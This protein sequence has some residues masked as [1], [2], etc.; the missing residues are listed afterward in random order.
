MRD[1]QDRAVEILQHIL[2]HLLARDIQM[3]CGLVQQEE[4]GLLQGQ[5]RQRQPAA[6]AAAQAADSFED[7]IFLKEK[8]AQIA[9]GFTHE[10]VVMDH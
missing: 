9:A 2:Q 10:H 5:D 6:L 7:V 1:Q 8:T 3:V 4:V